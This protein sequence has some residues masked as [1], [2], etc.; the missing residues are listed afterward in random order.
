MIYDDL[1]NVTTIDPERDDSQFIRP[2]DATIMAR[3]EAFAVA[4]S[5]PYLGYSSNV[6]NPD[7]GYANVLNFLYTNGELAA[8]LKLTKDGYEWAHTTSYRFEWAQLLNAISL[9]D[10]YYSIDIS[11]QTVITY[12]NKGENGVV[13]DNNG[14]KV[15]VVDYN[16]EFRALTVERYMIGQS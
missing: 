3:L 7:V 1:G 14:L 4:F 6:V 9:G 13:H 11:A 16:G 8:R 10:G 5:D 2:I 15:L 12:P